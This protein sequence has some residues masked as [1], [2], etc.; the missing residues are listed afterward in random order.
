M[1]LNADMHTHACAV[2]G[3]SQQLVQPCCTQYTSNAEQRQGIRYRSL[4]QANVPV[5][6]QHLRESR[7][8]PTLIPALILQAS[9]RQPR[10]PPPQP[11]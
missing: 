8:A 9:S 2:L 3:S 6:P 1:P 7:H 5:R 10:T 11:A 4:R